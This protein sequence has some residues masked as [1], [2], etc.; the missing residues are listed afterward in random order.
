MSDIQHGQPADVGAENAALR[1]QLEQENVKLRKQIADA[2]QAQSGG[3]TNEGVRRL[4]HPEEFVDGAPRAGGPAEDGRGD[5][6]VAQPDDGPVR[7]VEPV[8]PAAETGRT[9]REGFGVTPAGAAT[10]LPAPAPQSLL[11]RAEEKA[12]ELR[13]RMLGSDGQL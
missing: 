10:P 3:L 4:E 2:Q 11:E 6:E 5:D 12:H 13:Q 7:Q 1:D 9:D 8:A